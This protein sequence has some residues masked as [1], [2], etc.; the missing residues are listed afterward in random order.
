MHRRTFLQVAGSALLC[1]ACSLDAFKDPPSAKLRSRPGGAPLALP[2]GLTQRTEEGTTFAAYLPASAAALERIPLMLFLH[3]ANRTVDVFME[4]F[5]P[6][7]DATGVMLLMPYSAD[8]TW[9]AIRRSF[10]PDVA[11]IDRSLQWIFGQAPIDP[12]RLALS[13]FSDGA[14]YTLALGRANGDLF[15]SRLVA[16]SPGYLIP[17]S[18]VGHPPIVISHGTSDTVLPFWNTRDSIVPALRKDGYTVDFRPF[19][20][21]HAVPLSVVQE[22]MEA[23]AGG[24]A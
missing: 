8:Y 1:S 21:A 17:V 13:G 22:Q 4:R 9:D 24:A 5:R 10:G 2:A 6:I 15:S 7:A 12:T 19:D 11:G 16:Y 23:L 14:T 20:G 3:G 18:A